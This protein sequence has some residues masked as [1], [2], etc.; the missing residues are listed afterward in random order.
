MKKFVVP[1]LIGIGAASPVKAQLFS[2]E[3][4]NGALFGGIAGAIIGHNSGRHGGEGAAIGAGVGW[5]LGSIAHESRVERGY[6]SSPYGYGYTY[7]PAYYHRPGHYAPA[8]TYAQSAPAPAMA[9]QKQVTIINNNYYNTP[10]SAMNG[11]NA[12]FGR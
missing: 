3:S 6:Y 4:F 7:G 10:S 5:L 2:P 1:L 12:L 8:V 11:A 9:A